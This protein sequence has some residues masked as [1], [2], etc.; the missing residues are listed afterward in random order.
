MPVDIRVVIN[1]N[2][3][4]TDIDLWVT[5]PHGEKCYY[6]NASTAIGGRISDDF[7]Q[8]FGPEQFMLKKAAKGKYKIEVNYYGENQVS[9]SGA[10]TI[11]AEI[12]TR[13]S[14]GQQERKIISLQMPKQHKEGVL[15]G[16]FSF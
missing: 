9:L 3:N 14:D 11:M 15:I 7:T 6:S 12:Y 2:K 8:G 4:D 10:T 1:W 5:D 13:Y 16:T